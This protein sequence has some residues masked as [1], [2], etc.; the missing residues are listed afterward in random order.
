[1]LETRVK[2]FFK[3]QKLLAHFDDLEFICELVSCK[4][5]QRCSLLI[6]NFVPYFSARCNRSIALFMNNI[7]PIV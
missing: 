7:K 2:S 5:S 6:L 1:M 3:T 4:F